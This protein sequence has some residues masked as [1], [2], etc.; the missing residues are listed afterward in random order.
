MIAI[1]QSGATIGRWRD[2]AVCARAR[3]TWQVVFATL[4][5]ALALHAWS[6]FDAAHG[7][8]PT[9]PAAIFATSMIVNVLIA[10]IG[11]AA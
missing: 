7:G 5:I 4:A 2:A 9:P 6:L 10:F 3:I 11:T 1:A 8:V